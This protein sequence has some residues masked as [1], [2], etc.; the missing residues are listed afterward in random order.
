V[1]Y[2]QWRVE[3]EEGGGASSVDAGPAALGWLRLEYRF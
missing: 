3:P 2:Q 1:V